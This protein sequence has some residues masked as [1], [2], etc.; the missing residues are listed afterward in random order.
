[1]I[2]VIITLLLVMI[3]SIASADIRKTYHKSSVRVLFLLLIWFIPF[4]GFSCYYIYKS[5]MH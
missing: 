4:M 5:W 2:L 1:M 3:N